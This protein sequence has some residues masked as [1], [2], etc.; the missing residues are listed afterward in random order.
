M[1]YFLLIIL[2]IIFLART[3]D[4]SSSV[5]NLKSE[6][7]KIKQKLA[8]IEGGVSQ[9]SSKVSI[10]DSQRT[11]VNYAEQRNGANNPETHTYVG[12]TEMGQPIYRQPARVNQPE[13]S[14]PDP[15]LAWIQENWLL[16]LGVLMILIGFGWF[17]SYA[18]MH[19]WIGP[20]GRIAIGIVAGSFISIF[21]T[22]R[23]GKD[24]TQG[25]L[26]TALGAA[27]VIISVL[28]GQYFYQFFSPMIVLGIIFLVS[29]YVSLTA[30]AYSVEKLAIYGLI[31]ALLAPVLS[32]V[33]MNLDYVS[34]YLY[35]LVISISTI[36][37]SIVKGWRFGNPIGIVGILLYSFPIM[38]N[39]QNSF[40][41]DS[42]KYTTLILAYVISLLYL[43]VSSWSL[44]KKDNTLIAENGSVALAKNR[45]VNSEESVEFGATSN[46]VLLTVVSTII[47]LGLTLG[48]VPMI[49]Q[50]LVLSMWMLIYGVSG[51][52]VFQATR[53]EKLF[54]IHSLVAVLFLAIATS[55]ELSGKSLIIAFAIE[56]AIVS[57]ASFLV[58]NNIKISKAFGALMVIPMAMSLESVFSSNWEYE[59][60]MGMF[61]VD[62][63]VLFLIGVILATLGMFYRLNKE[64]DSMAPEFDFYH[65]SLIFSTVYLYVIIWLSSHAVIFNQDTAVFVSLFMYTV[66]GLGTYFIGLFNRSDILKKYG[67]VLLVLVVL[68]LVLVDVWQM[69]LALRVVTFIILGVMFISTAFISKKQQ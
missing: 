51:F 66:I 9:S 5:R 26:F 69:E 12:V 39:A 59:R 25:V 22:I 37:V 54:Y 19:D 27:L 3:S 64:K 32:H 13:T 58:T 7:Y 68:R 48:L 53:N 20:V 18:F 61:H 47:I 29:F 43:V 17:V 34:I 41:S 16:K 42:A 14:T 21:G 31:L 30:L 49:Y 50:S 65:L 2:G 36:W 33:S 67:G 24:E 4:L 45:G 28:S 63:F 46:D 23:L 56:A 38:M 40:A 1:I 11:D 10:S 8:E 60:G 15:V 62:F 35:L 52:I 55:V 6:V 57:I 44:I